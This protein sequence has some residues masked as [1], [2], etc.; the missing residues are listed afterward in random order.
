MIFPGT[1]VMLTDREFPW[2]SF[3]PFLKMGKMFPIFQSTGTLPDYHDLSNIMES[4]LAT[5]SA[6][7]LR[8]LGCISSGPTDLSTF[9]FS[10]WS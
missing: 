5:T 8:T 7:S 3:L 10:R 6:N 4:G 1:E 2:S 9:R